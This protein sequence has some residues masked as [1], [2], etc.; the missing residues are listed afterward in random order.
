MII[1]WIQNHISLDRQI[2]LIQWS[3]HILAIPAVIWA[4]YNQQYYW[5]IVS[6]LGWIVFGGISIV[7][8]LHRLICHR[9]YKTW[10]WLEMLFT[11]MTIPST[12]GPTIAWVALHRYHHRCSDSERDPHS[13]IVNGKFSFIQSLNVWLGWDWKVRTIPVSFGRDLLKHPR[14]RFIFDHYW[15]MMFTWWAFLF[16]IS[17]KLWLFLYVVPTSWSLNSLGTL[18]ILG[19]WQGY[20]NYD[21]KDNSTNSWIANIIAFGD[22]WHNTHHA[23]PDK[24]HLQE[25]WWE[26]DIAGEFIKLI[27]ISDK[28]ERRYGNYG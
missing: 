22:G 4:L 24:W 9:S 14:H 13:P 7:V 2:R 21:I 8:V 5:L 10:D 27:K 16:I 12:V 6:F 1:K 25:K 26:I 3:C 28:D 20:R 18:N 15:K 11:Y 19:H 17:P 23:R